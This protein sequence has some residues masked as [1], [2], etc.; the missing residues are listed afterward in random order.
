[1]TATTKPGP[2][3]RLRG[4]SGQATLETIAYLPY[5]LVMF[6][7]ALEVFAFIMTIEEVDSAARAGARVAG[8]GGDGYSAAY[9]ALPN[10]L[11]NSQTRIRVYAT[12]DGDAFASVH[13][14]VPLIYGTS[15]DWS[16]TREVTMPIG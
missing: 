2:T 12:R 9:D 4:S 14:Q 10:R 6:L 8:Q 1:M 11:H 5:V 16:V 7:L 15:L 3:R 13:A